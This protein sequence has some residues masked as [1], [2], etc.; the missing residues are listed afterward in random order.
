MPQTR[1]QC[2]D[3]HIEQ[4]PNYAGPG[5]NRTRFRMRNEQ[6]LTNEEA[7]TQLQNQWSI[8]H[9]ARILEWNN[10][11][12]AQQLL[13]DVV[14]HSEQSEARPQ[15]PTPTLPLW[16]NITG[17]QTP[18]AQQANTYEMSPL[19]SSP[20]PSSLQSLSELLQQ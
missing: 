19:L 2:P 16:N 3:P 14:L 18:N 7:I 11:Q 8:E 9:N 20:Y 6:N 5:Y 4:M 12:Q 17:N 10:Q 15:T 13:N 1:K